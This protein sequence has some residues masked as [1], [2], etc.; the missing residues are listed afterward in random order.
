MVP[1]PI[2]LVIIH[3]GHE[4]DVDVIGGRTD[5]H[6]AGP[7]LEMPRGV[8]PPAQRPVDPITTSTPA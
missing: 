8:F 6:L 1:R 5:Q 4:R 7:G 2:V 3:A